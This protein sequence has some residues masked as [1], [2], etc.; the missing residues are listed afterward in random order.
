MFGLFSNQKIKTIHWVGFNMTKTIGFIIAA[1]GILIYA[2][3][4]LVG[5]P[6]LQLKD[7][8][9]D[10]YNMPYPNESEQRGHDIYV[11]NGCVYCHSM[12]PR[13][14]NFGPDTERGWGRAAVPSDYA[15]D[16]PHQL[17]TMR[18]GPDL[19]NIGS[20][21]TSKDWHLVHLYQPRAV[22]K[23][24]VMPAYRFLYEEKDPDKIERND[25]I[26]K[27]DKKYNKSGKVIVA[28]QGAVDLVN[29]LL[30]LKRDFPT[31]QLKIFEKRKEQ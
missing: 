4:L 1:A 23:N 5:V 21:Q 25:V 20:R 22:L 6:Y 2:T 15:Y 12:Q 29:Y 8:T 19:H 24:S 17:G 9:I 10:V 3:I 14:K 11:K 28:K 30:S 26:V 27:I 16:Y 7:Q 31:D 13:D 18:T